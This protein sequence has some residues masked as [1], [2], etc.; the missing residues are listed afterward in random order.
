MAELRKTI[1]E[2]LYNAVVIVGKACINLY[3]ALKAIN[4]G[5]VDVSDFIYQAST[6]GVDSI[7]I[8][9]ITCVFIGMALALHM[10][11]ELIETYGAE[12]VA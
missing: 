5:R 7:T 6:R 12:M 8:I 3:S 4:K 9:V 2:N 1:K 10:T 11:N